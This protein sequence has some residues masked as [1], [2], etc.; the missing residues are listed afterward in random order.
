MTVSSARLRETAVLAVP[1]EELVARR[2][3]AA[4]TRNSDRRE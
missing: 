1:L 2:G 3:D 4:T